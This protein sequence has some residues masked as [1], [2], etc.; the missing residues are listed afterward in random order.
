MKNVRELLRLIEETPLEG[1]DV[2]T[3]GLLQ[4]VAREARVE[5]DLVVRDTA[6]QPSEFLRGVVNEGLELAKSRYPELDPATECSE[7]R[8]VHAPSGT[9]LEAAITPIPG[10]ASVRRLVRHTISEHGLSVDIA[11]TW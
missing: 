7:V 9:R 3:I 2:A 6:G 4:L 5:F 11:T 1:Y 8:V 10:D